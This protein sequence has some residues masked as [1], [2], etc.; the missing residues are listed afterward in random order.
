MA[1]GDYNALMSNAKIVA[2]MQNPKV[3]EIIDALR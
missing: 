2:L 3:R 1:A